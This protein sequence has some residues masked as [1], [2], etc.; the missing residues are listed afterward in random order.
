MSADDAGEGRSSSAGEYDA[1]AS[2]SEIR[3]LIS[4]VNSLVRVSNLKRDMA[5]EAE[6]RVAKLKEDK[7]P[8]LKKK[9][10]QKQFDV[11]EDVKEKL[12]EPEMALN[13]TPVAIERAKTAIQE[14]MEI[15]NKRQKL[16]KIADRSE[17]GWATVDEYVEDELADNSDDEKHLFKAEAR[18]GRKVKAIQAAKLKKKKGTFPRKP[19]YATSSGMATG[20]ATGSQQLAQLPWQHPGRNAYPPSQN[21]GPCFQSGKLG[22]FRKSCPLL[23]SSSGSNR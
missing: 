9:G 2:R 4:A 11:N 6:A 3:Q 15:I 1:A 21:L 13:Q 18:A 14:G 16:I 19:Q 10:H 17:H 8:S 20:L 12:S 23:Q 5:D 7:Q 22:H